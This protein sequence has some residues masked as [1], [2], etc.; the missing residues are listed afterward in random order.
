MSGGCNLSA[1]ATNTQGH[2]TLDDLGYGSKKADAAPLIR[3]DRPMQYVSLHHH[4]TFSN[5]DGYGL[6]EAHVRR[7]AELNMNSI[8]ITD[9]GTVSGHIKM[10]QAGDKYGIK[11]IFGV[12]LYTGETDEELRTQRKNHLTVI[13]ANEDGYRNLLGVVSAGWDNFYYEPTVDGPTLARFR[14]GLFI[15]S[16][17]QGS[18]LATSLVGG[19]NVKEE[20]ASYVKAK[21]CA[22]RLKAAFGDRFFLEVQMFPELEKSKI[23]NQAY[24]RLSEE[25]DIPLVASGDVHYTTPD[26]SEMQMI[27]HNVRGGNKQTLEE[28]ARAWG[29]DTKLCHPLSDAYVIK[30]LRATGMS[31]KAAQQAV[32]STALIAQECNVRIPKLDRVRF[33]LPP[34]VSGLDYVMQKI[35]EGWEY[36]RVNMKS[37]A[38]IKR[39]K[40]RM[41][42]EL[43]MIASKDFIDYFLVVSDLVIWAKDNAITVGPGRG[44]AAASLVCWLLRITEVDPM[45]FP[46][47][48]FE[49]FIDVTRMDL[50]DIDLDFDDVRRPEVKQYLIRKYGEDKVA[51]IGTFTKY[52]AKNSLDDIARVYNIPKFEVEKVKD[53][54][55]ER[56]SGDLR[57]N[58]TIED[59]VDSFPVVAEVFERFP[60]LYK[61]MLLEGNY[62]GFGVHA[63]GLVVSS[64]PI[65]NV[66]AVYTRIMA[67]V[68]QSVISMDMN[69][70]VYANVLKIDALGLSTCGLISEALMLLDMTLDDLYRIPL[71]DEEVIKGFKENDVVGIFQ[72]DGRAMRQV[73]Q[74][75]KPDSFKEVADINALAR[76]GP[77]HGGATA[78]YIDVKK[79]EKTAR[80]FHPLV[81]AICGDTYG[82]IVYQEQILRIVREVGNFDWTHASYI[83]KIIS[84]K[85]GEQEFERQYQKF[86]DGAVENGLTTEQAREIWNSCITAG[87]Y[88]FNAA[89]SY[90]Y[91][92]LAWW[93][94]WLK[95]KHPTE[96]YV[97][98]LRRM[99]ETKTLE[100]LKD[101]ARKN[102]WILNP[103][104]MKSGPTWKAEGKSIRAGLMQIK[105]IGEKMAPAMIEFRDTY[106]KDR[107][108]KPKDFEY[109]DLMN[110]RGVG[111]KKVDA[112]KQFCDMDDPFEI[113]KV[114]RMLNRIR[115]DLIGG[116]PY[117]YGKLPRTTHT[118]VQVPYSRGEDQTIVWTGLVVSK[119]LRD[120]FELHYSRTGEDLD[121]GGL[122]SPELKEYMNLW[123]TDETDA[124]IITVDRYNYPKFKKLL[125]AIKPNEDVILVQG[126]KYGFQ[127][128]RAIYAKQIW[129]LGQ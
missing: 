53:M 12:E 121:P 88:A 94:M 118:T 32:E 6:P 56:S 120:I 13:A 113:F 84:K 68:P 66:A 3:A 10:E 44:S 40:A 116:I 104:I 77:L 5:L 39:Y 20:E 91:G 124:L 29:Y 122:K 102:I 22:R 58:S 92:M 115:Q 36:R 103:S 2:E 128:R 52:K 78:E 108:L 18:L 15:L 83:R 37:S 117:K 93:T 61:A 48:V 85:I 7:A 63:A 67:G 110:M 62:R 41:K 47:L 51:N 81:D 95:R 26:E 57:A 86:H 90:S 54:M 19:K 87:A 73:N 65:T 109:A 123:C 89:H 71:D 28:Q 30:Q 98:A 129:I 43:D 99:P 114:E 97:A 49:R 16:G 17:C 101:A 4:T 106:I 31:L 112:I 59:T 1:E 33:P 74:E 42:Y 69:D 55:L 50:P 127:A 100:L 14:K 82:Q 107:G 38:D 75:V 125:W 79:G 34:G 70:S 27:L 24:E 9:H 126:I 35:R 64:E 23:I 72:F 105:G 25:L 76:P 119:N 11:P 80:S 111:Q 96:F 45:L 21:K 60:D 46:A 8:A